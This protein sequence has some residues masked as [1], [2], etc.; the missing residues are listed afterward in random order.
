L[1]LKQEKCHLM[2]KRGIF[3]GHLISN[4]G[5]GVNEAK[6]NLIASLT[7]PTFMN[8]IKSF[9]RCASLSNSSLRITSK[10]L[11]TCVAF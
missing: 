5:I 1:T 7:P 3:L 11:S 10:L 8:D 6:I 9:L 4:I 2:V